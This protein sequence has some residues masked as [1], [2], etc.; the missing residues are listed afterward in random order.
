MDDLI[1]VKDLADKREVFTK[2]LESCNG[3]IVKACEKLDL[4]SATLYNWM[5]KDKKF[6]KEVYKVREMIV[7]IAESEL[8]KRLF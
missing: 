6:K 5:E 4:N 2:V 1:K 8:L 7:D 3:V